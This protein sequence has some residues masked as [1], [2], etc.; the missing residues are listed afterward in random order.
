MGPVFV[1]PVPFDV[2]EDDFF[3]IDARLG[4]NLA[5]RGDDEALPPELDPVATGGCFV[6]DA[7]DRGDETAVGNRMTALDRFPGGMLSVA[8]LRFLRSDASRSPSDKRESRAPCSA[9]RRAAS[10]YH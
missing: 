1:D 10:G 5:A 8:V 9:V 7:V 4:E 3:A 6:A 2:G